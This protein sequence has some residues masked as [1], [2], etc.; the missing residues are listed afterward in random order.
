MAS[1][2]GKVKF[3]KVEKEKNAYPNVEDYIDDPLW[4]VPQRDYLDGS[5]DDDDDPRFSANFNR[6]PEVNLKNVLSGIVAILTGQNK[7]GG[8]GGGGGRVP[9]SNVS[10]LESEKN[11]DTYLHSSVYIPSA[12]PLLEPNYS[13]VY[14]DVLEAEPPEWLPDSST[15]VC[16]QCTAPFTAISRGRH[17]CRF[18]GGVFCRTCTKGRCLLPVKFRERNPQ[19]V[20]DTCYDRLDPLQGVLINTISN[21]MQVAKHDVVDWTCTRGWLNLPLGFSMEHEVYKASNT[22]RSY[23]QVSRLNP[24][25]SIP[26]AILKGAKGLAILTVAKAG[27]IVAYKLGTG[28]VIARRSDGSW[29]APSA[30]CSVGLGWG[31]QIGGELMDYIIVLHDYKAVKTFCSRMHFSLGAGCSAAA[32][33]VGRVLEA[34]LHAGDRG[35]GMCYTYSCS[36]GAF[37]GVSLEGNI[38]ATRTETNLKFYGDPYLSTADILLGTVDRPKAAEPLYAALGE[39]YSSLRH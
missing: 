35:S 3:C 22:L 31:A 16:M 7:D 11:G 27:A 25:K 33:P 12:P 38:L 19:R 2:E 36:K 6:L 14:K 39:L 17:H 29:S 34:D 13:T 32:G 24:E 18:C 37:V 21:A 9:S 26:L 20:C 8:G 4:P 23:W 10:F 15:T 30:I 5:T 1:F 28:L